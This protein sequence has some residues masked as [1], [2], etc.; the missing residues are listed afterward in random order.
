MKH[1]PTSPR[2]ARMKKEV[3]NE[4]KHRRSKKKEATS[5]RYLLGLAGVALLAAIV[6]INSPTDPPTTVAEQ[7]TSLSP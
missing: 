5:S 1:R 4:N 2:I 3:A 6:A 7:P